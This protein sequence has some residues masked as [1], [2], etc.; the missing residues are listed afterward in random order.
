M[1]WT[2]RCANAVAITGV[3]F[4][5]TA[6]SVGDEMV[7]V[8]GPVSGVP[9]G[10]ID[11]VVKAY[12]DIDAEAV[13]PTITVTKGAPCTTADTCAK[14][15]KCDAGKCYWEPPVGELGDPCTYEQYCKTGSCVETTAGQLCSN[16]CVVGV[17]DSCGTGFTCDGAAGGTGYCVPEGAG[18]DTTCCGIGANG[19]TSALLSLFVVVFVL[20]RKRR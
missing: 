3:P 11:I 2:P 8:G 14:G 9:D 1:W 6:P 13:N 7:S 12:D 20:R 15:Q 4:W 17:G 19:K 16:E 18:D 10:I 5:I